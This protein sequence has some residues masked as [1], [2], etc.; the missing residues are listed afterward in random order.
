MAKWA[1]IELDDYSTTL[2]TGG[3]VVDVI[4][5]ETMIKAKHSDKISAGTHKIVSCSDDCK[6][7]WILT[8]K[9]NQIVDSNSQG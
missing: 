1:L 8:D 5:E 9:T 6:I 2:S 4:G 3:V 7:G